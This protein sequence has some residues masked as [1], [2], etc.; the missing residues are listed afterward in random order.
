MNSLR[1]R[2]MAPAAGNAIRGQAFRSIVDVADEVLGPGT[3]ERVLAGLSAPVAD[4]FR[5]H[6]IIASGWYPMEWYSEL[7]RTAA[8][9]APGFPHAIRRLGKASS[10]R[11]MSTVHRFLLKLASP[12]FAISQAARI[13]GLY[14]KE[15]GSEQIESSP[16]AVRMRLRIPGA[17]AELWED[18][19]GG[20]EAILEGTGV[21]Q[22]Q[23]SVDPSS[24]LSSAL[25]SAKWAV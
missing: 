14:M 4:A 25:L 5:Y 16:G 24:S 21:R 11:D 9:V 20:T 13:M 10:A 8:S 3:K 23:I 15:H 22:G 2:S 17:S 7:L 12:A 18:V 6:S 19:A 1:D